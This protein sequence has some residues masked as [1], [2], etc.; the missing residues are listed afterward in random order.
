M[1]RMSVSLNVSFLHSLLDLTG[2]GVQ[3]EPNMHPICH[4]SPLAGV[5]VGEEGRLAT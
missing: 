5:C 3:G 2:A 1:A 4:P